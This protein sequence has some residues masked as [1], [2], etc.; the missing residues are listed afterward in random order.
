MTLGDVESDVAQLRRGAVAVERHLG[1]G[2]DAEALRLVQDLEESCGA[3]LVVSSG[4]CEAVFA[5]RQ[6][7]REVRGQL[8]LDAAGAAAGWRTPARASTWRRGPMTC[9]AVRRPRA[10]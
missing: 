4:S 6:E 5:L 7:L 9:W 1:Q 2:Q 3:D 10:R 8:L